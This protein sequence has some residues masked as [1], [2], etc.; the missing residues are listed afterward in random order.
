MDLGFLK[1]SSHVK[2]KQGWW[3][4]IMHTNKRRTNH[5]S[6][7]ALKGME[8]AEAATKAQHYG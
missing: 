8:G 1:K 7:R 3:T 5:V 2:V 6:V 4:D